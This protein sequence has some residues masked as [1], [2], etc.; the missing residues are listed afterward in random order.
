MRAVVTGANRGIG[1]ELARQLKARGVEVLA[2]CRRPSSELSELGVELIQGVD[3]A[4]EEGVARLAQGVAGRGVDLL[5]NNA[6]VLH[7]NRLDALDW[8]SIEAQM[9]VN[10]FGPLRVVASL[11]DSLGR[12]AK[13]AIVTSRMGSLADNSSG[14]HYGYRMSKAAANM[15][16]VSLA[17]DLAP[18]GVSVC[19]LHPGYVR[20]EMT[21]GRGNWNADEAAAGLLARIDELQLAST[22]SFWHADGQTLPW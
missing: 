11:R 21:G 1:L 19:L 6:G 13:V 22:G 8:P 3:V 4:S 14:S 17:R 16:G 2:A 5:V 12:G 9:Q 7:R 10:A 20:T 15:A 18:S